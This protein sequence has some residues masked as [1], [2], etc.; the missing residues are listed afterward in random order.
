MDNNQYGISRFYVKEHIDSLLKPN[1]VLVIYGPR[2]TGKTTLLKAYL[3]ECDFKYKMDNGDNIQ[4]REILRSSDFKLIKDYAAGYDL[5]AIDEAQQI[6]NVGQGFK[7]LADQVPGLRVIATGSSSFD[8]SY[9]IGEP[10]TGRKTTI[11]LYPLSQEELLKSFNPFELKQQLPETLIFGSYP[12]VFTANSSHE[13]KIL[14]DE[15]VNSSC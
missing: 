1:R 7:I 9:R 14:L 3:N 5:L 10:L 6:P 8:L 12:E 11:K 13:K 2:R 15:L 4:T